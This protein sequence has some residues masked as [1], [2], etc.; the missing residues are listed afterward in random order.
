MT[1]PNANTLPEPWTDP[2]AARIPENISEYKKI[3]WGI[4]T[5]P[6][7]AFISTS[8]NFRQYPLN[9]LGIDMDTTPLDCHPTKGW[10]FPEKELTSWLSLENSLLQ[11][12]TTLLTWARVTYPQSYLKLTPPP[13]PHTFE[14][15]K[16]H[17]TAQEARRCLSLGLE[18]FLILI[19][20]VSYAIAISNPN[21]DPSMPDAPWV[22][23]MLKTK[24]GHPSWYDGVRDSF[25]TDFSST[26]SHVGMICRVS[27]CPPE[28]FVRRLLSCRIPV[29]FYWGLPPL[30]PTSHAAAAMYQPLLENQSGPP[31][32]NPQPASKEHE[33]FKVEPNSRQRPGE[34]WRD[35]F[36]RKKIQTDL[37]KTRESSRERTSRLSREQAQAKRPEPGKKG[38]T[39]WYWEDKGGYR[40]RTMMSRGE[41]RR[42]WSSYG[43]AQLRYD[44]FSNEYDV[45][46]EFGSDIESDSEESPILPSKAPQAT[47]EPPEPL[48]LDRLS[49]ITTNNQPA[50]L[51]K[52]P[53]PAL[54][55]VVGE[56]STSSSLPPPQ[57]SCRDSFECSIPLLA[58]SAQIESCS[59]MPLTHT[60]SDVLMIDLPK[61]SPL[62]DPSPL[63]LPPDESASENNQPVLLEQC[64]PALDVPMV[65]EPSTL[66]TLPPPRCQSSSAQLS[67]SGYTDPLLDGLSGVDAPHL[68]ESAL[69]VLDGHSYIPPPQ[70]EMIPASDLGDLLY[71]RFGYIGSPNSPVDESSFTNR[72]NSWNMV[73][74]SVGG[75]SLGC[76][77]S[78]HLPIMCFLSLLLDMK[79]I[80]SHLWDLSPDSPEPLSAVLS[81]IHVVDTKLNIDASYF[82]RPQNL[83]PTRDCSWVLAVDS[84]AALQCLRQSLGPHTVGI[85][86][87]FLSCGMPFRTF[88]KFERPNAN[89]VPLTFSIP[90]LPIRLADYKPDLADYVTYDTIRD[91]FLRRSPRCRAALQL[92]GIVWRLAQM[93]LPDSAILSGPSQDALDGCCEV[94]SYGGEMFCDD[95]LPEIALDLICGVYKV[96]VRFGKCFHLS[97]YSLIIYWQDNLPKYLGG[98]NTMS[99]Y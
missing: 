31:L 47:K 1:S 62:V 87:E 39:I 52:I 83:H 67:L 22:R 20:Y 84:S 50:L 19:A 63:P 2:D 12:A 61:P 38:P 82:P 33:P 96:P 23:H 32:S 57:S 10:R 21:G 14:L 81:F 53:S 27:R 90:T 76:P 34:S 11:L 80:P 46:T 88:A 59:P 44:S 74:A 40:V 72:F 64:I 17:P 42:V 71:D 86:S 79:D 97:K 8:P 69:D 75:H 55:V 36:A 85:A 91:S 77:S 95:T 29:W 68:S 25:I 54:D 13:L 26:A 5:Y 49:P 18:S 28:Y 98:L 9:R 66:S 92:G 16:F 51:E 41:A 3:L 89:Y 93:T 6:Y 56:P 15:A 58:S 35:Y 37:R 65:S 70:E 99:G 4:P 94:I 48:V 45:C 7:L 60:S 30:S 73:C 78:E 24:R 43:N